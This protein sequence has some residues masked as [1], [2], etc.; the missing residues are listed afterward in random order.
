MEGIGGGNQMPKRAKEL[1]NLAVKRLT[2]K[3]LHA[4][5]GVDGLHLQINENGAKSWI[6]R[7]RVNNKRRDIGLGSFPTI[8]LSEAREN[9]RRIRQDVR[10]GID[11]VQERKEKRNAL[12]ASRAAEITFEMASTQFI[13]VKSTEWKGEKQKQV[14]ENSLL[15]YAYPLIGKLQVKDI[16]LSHI[17]KILEP[18]WQDKTETAVRLRGRIE[19][20]LDWATVRKYRTGDNP[21]RWKGHLDK[22]L[23]NPEKF[24]KKAHFPALPLNQIKD[25][26]TSLYTKDGFG[27]QALAFL[28]LTVARSGEVRGATWDEIDFSAKTWTIPAARM[29]AGKEHRIPLSDAAIRILQNQPRHD[30]VNYIFPALRGGKLSDTTLLAVMRR[31]NVTAVPHGFRSTFRDWVAEHTNF[32]NEVAEMALAHTIKS[33]VESAYRRGDLFKKRK[34]MMT[35]WASF[36]HGK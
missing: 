25:F 14:W 10:Q 9:A 35:K 21:A 16:E 8:S 3:G 4:V 17:V 23:P 30:G 15:E 29:K 22:I 18:I 12:Q 20:I 26:M 34:Q 27:S 32:P 13:A 33:R 31:M 24:R 2:K 1:S 19:N 28:I 5:G 6:L 7:I 11:P 36:C